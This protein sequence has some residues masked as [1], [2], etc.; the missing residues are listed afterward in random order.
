MSDDLKPVR[1]RFAPSPTGYLHI[2]GVRT[3]LFAWL[4]ARQAGGQFILRIEDTDQQRLVDGSILHIGDSLQWLLSQPQRS[5]PGYLDQEFVWDEGPNLYG[6]PS[7]YDPYI[8]SSRVAKK[9]SDGLNI[10]E[11]YAMRLVQAGRAYA[12]PCTPEQIQSFRQDAQASKKAFLYRDYVD[13]DTFAPNDEWTPGCGKSLRLKSHPQSYQ[14]QD[15]VMGDLSAPEVVVDDIVLIK[16]DGYPTYN[17]AH[18][19]DDDDMGITHVIRGQEFIA[20]MP[21][22]LNIYDAL[23]IDWRKL[24]FATVPAIM[25][26]EGNK[27]LSKRDGAKDL[28]D[29]RDE[30]FFSFAMCNFLASLGW[31]DGTTKEFYRVNELVESF[32]LDRIQ[33]SGARFDER[34]ATWLNG[35]T[36]R[37]IYENPDKYNTTLYDAVSPMK[38]TPANPADTGMWPNAAYFG[39][40]ASREYREQVLGVVYDR[41]KFLNDLGGKQRYEG[42]DVS[43]RVDLTSYFFT[44]PI[45]DWTMVDG[46]KQLAKFDRERH[47]ELLQ[48]ASLFLESSDYDKES[49]Q[50]TLN[51]LLEA[52]GEKPGTLFSL[53]RFALTW[54]PFS[55]GLPETMAIL[56]PEKTLGR[57][58]R[59]IEAA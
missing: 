58:R 38:D 6:N 33:R 12:D 56:G 18:I 32:S 15:T 26:S 24:V 31:N 37:D 49:L 46:N 1:T 55:P 13:Q 29:F 28:L 51:K 36:I 14:W 53:I 22:Y 7:S 2:G 43:E 35:M 25:N 19:V 30:G 17:F 5:L 3:A 59:A 45:P 44:E 10:Y 39:P 11:K 40:Y 20:S 57:F 42:Q 21:N 52:T 50:E 9:D 54:A 8:Q 16:S 34:R 23:G 48:K 47:V 41:M 27:K 4:V